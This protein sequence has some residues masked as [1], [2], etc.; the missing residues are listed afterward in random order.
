MIASLL[1]RGIEARLYFPPAHLQ[2]VF[3]PAG[4]SLPR[5][6]RLAGQMLSIP[7]HSRLSKDDLDTMADLMSG[8]SENYV[9][10]DAGRSAPSFTTEESDATKSER[11]EAAVTPAEGSLG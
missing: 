4:V 1:E 11:N 10:G 5:T 3:R 6:E 9:P 7:C 2:H 8:G